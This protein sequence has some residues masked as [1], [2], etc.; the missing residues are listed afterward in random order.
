MTGFRTEYRT[1]ARQVFECCTGYAQSGFGCIGN[2]FEFVVRQSTKWSGHGTIGAPQNVMPFVI[3]SRNVAYC[4]GIF[5][6]YRIV[7]S[8]NYIAGYLNRFILELFQPFVQMD[9][10]M[11]DVPHLVNANVTR[12]T[13]AK[14]AHQVSLYF[15]SICELVLCS[16]LI[17]FVTM[18]FPWKSLLDN[19]V[20]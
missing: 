9:V 2:V 20:A 15:M 8:N 6:P 11:V 13:V 7:F 18:Y 4:Y 3:W 14:I 1:K 17:Q 16:I 5:N 10:C 12:D 19:R